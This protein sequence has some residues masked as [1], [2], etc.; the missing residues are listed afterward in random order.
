MS[1]FFRY[2]NHHIIPTS[3]CRGYR[4]KRAKLHYTQGLSFQ[5]KSRRERIA[6]VLESIRSK[7]AKKKIKAPFTAT[8]VIPQEQG[9]QVFL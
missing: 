8:N 5:D 7:K 6:Q 3:F 2:S 9:I 4:V 1:E